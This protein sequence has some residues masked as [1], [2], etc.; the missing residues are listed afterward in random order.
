MNKPMKE[1]GAMIKS[2]VEVKLRSKQITEYIHMTI[3]GP[4]TIQKVNILYEFFQ[5]KY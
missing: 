1:I 4:M 3:F 5:M 2:M